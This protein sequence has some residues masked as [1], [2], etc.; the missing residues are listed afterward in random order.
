MRRAAGIRGRLGAH[1]SPRPTPRPRHLRDG[2]RDRKQLGQDATAENNRIHR[3]WPDAKIKRT[4]PRSDRFGVPGRIVLQPIIDGE[5]ITRE[6]L[7]SPRNGALRNHVTPL[8]PALHG[9]LR[10]HHRVCSD[11]LVN[12]AG[13]WNRPCSMSNGQSGHLAEQ[14]QAMDR[15]RTVPGMNAHAAAIILAAIGTARDQFGEDQQVAAWAGLR[16]G[17]HERAEKNGCDRVGVIVP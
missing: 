13:S 16:P 2:T 11:F 9:R 10:R 15:L 4:P 3:I 14:P 17:H 12:L 5:V 8:L 6:F 7:E 1:R